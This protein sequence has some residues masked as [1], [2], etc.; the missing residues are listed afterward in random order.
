MPNFKDYRPQFPSELRARLAALQFKAAL[1][2]LC[3]K[4]NF[5][6][7]QPRVPAGN[8]EGGQ[9]TANTGG[10]RTSLRPEAA[11]RVVRDP[12]GEKPWRTYAER[13]RSDGS[14][15]STT[16]YNRN[17]SVIVSERTNADTERNVVTL[18]DGS[19]FTFENN[20]DTQ[21]IYDAAGKLVSETL[22]ASEGP[23]A[24]PIV[25]QA[26]FDSR[27]PK[28]GPF[29]SP[30]E[31]VRD[32]A[33]EL[34]NWWLNSRDPGEEVIFSFRA[35]KLVPVPG[36][37]PLWTSKL[38]REEVEDACPRF[39]LVQNITN[40]VAKSLNPVLFKNKGAYGTAVHMGVKASIDALRDS[41]LMTEV[42]IFKSDIDISRYALKGTVR[43]DILEKREDNFVC[44][45]DLKT[46]FYPMP[47]KRFLEIYQN[48]IA[49]YPKVTGVIIVEVRPALRP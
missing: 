25:Q 47:T 23:I 37:P 10:A 7:S 31:V 8:A 29:S 1:L 19:R 46:G 3:L 11:V 27:K 5:N 49:R 44:V 9:W 14:L 45:Y 35:D 28:K 34:Y 30:A 24:Q 41:N 16:V 21:R 26:L 18:G 13:R 4:A 20:D 17:G 36:E 38:T 42:S 6:P 33:I 22:W 12:S 43:I 2:R 48:V 15:A 32:A 40:Q 39:P